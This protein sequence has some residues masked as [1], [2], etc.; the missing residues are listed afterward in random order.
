MN[1]YGHSPYITSS[2]ATGWVCHLKMLPALASA[3][4]LGLVSPP[5][6]VEL[7]RSYPLLCFKRFLGGGVKGGPRVRLTTSQPSVS[8]LSRKC[9]SLDGSEPDEPS[10][11]LAGLACRVGLTTSQQ[12]VSRLSRKCGSLDV[13]QT[14]GPPRPVTGIAF[15]LPLPLRQGIQ[16]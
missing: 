5:S 16:I 12:P 14:Y 4:I 11:P 2:L 10:R 8:R 7:L 15:P 6:T 1:T 3:F 13:L 9:G